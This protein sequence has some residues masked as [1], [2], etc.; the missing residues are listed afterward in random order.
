MEKVIVEDAPV[1]PRFKI[2]VTKNTK[3]YNYVVSVRNDSLKEL[4]EEIEDLELWAKE[5]YGN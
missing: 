3:G 1:A 5:K 4:K 2:E